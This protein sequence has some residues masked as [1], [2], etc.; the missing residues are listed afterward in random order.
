MKDVR[1]PISPIDSESEYGSLVYANSIDNDGELSRSR[2]KN[3]SH[4]GMNTIVL[5]TGSSSSGRRRQPSGPE[6]SEF[7][8][9]RPGILIGSTAPRLN[10]SRTPSASSVSGSEEDGPSTRNRA[11]SAAIA[12]ALGLSQTPPS[13]YGKMGGPGVIRRDG[14]VGRRKADP[15]SLEEMEKALKEAKIKTGNKQ[16]SSSGSSSQQ[17]LLYRADTTSSI[18]TSRKD[19]DVIEHGGGGVKSHRSNTIQTSSPSSPVKL[20]MRALTSPKFDRDKALDGTGVRKERKERVRKARVCLKCLK[21]IANERWVSVDGG[22][23]LCE[24]CWKNMYLPKVSLAFHSY[25]LV[26]LIVFFSVSSLQFVNREASGIF[27]RWSTKRQISQRVLQLRYLSCK[28]LLLELKLES[29]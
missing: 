1:R 13:D 9:D 6:Q 26:D 2:S 21:A 27:F 23:V 4:P 7:S 11:N 10:R 28:Y 20:P 16:P 5:R 3:S 29:A 22:G 15:D 17:S 18:A 12:H 25:M 8:I 19:S 14:S 24:M